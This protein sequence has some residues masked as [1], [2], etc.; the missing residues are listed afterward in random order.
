M[1]TFVPSWVE[2]TLP[3]EKKQKGPIYSVA[4][5][6]LGKRLATAGGDN[7]VKIWSTEPMF[8]SEL[9]KN[10]DT[11]RLLAVLATHQGS[12]LCV[13]WSHDM[14]SGSL[15]ASGSD[16]LKIIIWQQQEG[17]TA[18]PAF[19]ETAGGIESWRPKKL[20][21]GHTSDIMDLAWSSENK[22]LA[23]C[24]IESPIY[25]WDGKSFELIRK[26]QGH[27]SFVKGITWDPAGVYLASQS[28]DKTV[29]IW[30]T[31][32]WQEEKSVSAPYE[33]A[34]STSF[35]MRLAWSPEG[36]SILTTSGESGNQA[37][38][39][40]IERG[41]WE[42]DTKLV[43]PTLPVECA[44]FNPILFLSEPSGPTSE[45]SPCT[46]CAVGSQDSTISIWRT[47]DEKAFMVAKDLFQHSVLDMCWGPGGDSLY[48]CSYDGTVAVMLWPENDE[49]GKHA[50]L[51]TK[52][53]AMENLGSKRRTVIE[54]ATQLELEQSGKAMEISSNR[55]DTLLGRSLSTDANQP[56][57]AT[58]APAPKRSLHSETVVPLRQ[59]VS[60]T[61]DGRKRIRPTFLPSNFDSPDNA[62]SVFD[63][64]NGTDDSSGLIPMSLSKRRKAD[65]S[66]D[67]T[68]TRAVTRYVLPMVTET[69]QPVNLALPS[70]ESKL[71][72][73]IPGKAP[74]GTSTIECENRG[75]T[76]T[77]TCTVKSQKLW[78][79]HLHSHAIHVV[80]TA[81]FV[82]IGCIDGS[83]FTFSAAGRRLLP[84]IAL[85]APS[86]F[87]TAH[88]QYLMSLSSNA[89]LSVWNVARRSVV[90][91]QTSIAHLLHSAA[92][93][94]DGAGRVP[95]KDVVIKSAI[96][97]PEGI[98]ILTTSEDNQYSFHPGMKVWI[99]VGDALEPVSGGRSM[100]R[101][102]TLAQ[103]ENL[104]A[105]NTALR[106][107][108]D[109]L[110]NIKRYAIKLCDENATSKVEELCDELLGHT[111]V[112]SINMVNE[113]GPIDNWNPMIMGIPKR[114]ILQQLI[115]ILSQKR[116][117]QRIV[118]PV[119]EHLQKITESEH[120][121]RIRL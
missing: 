9:E 117:F 63:T 102:K 79:D 24:G 15:L 21:A 81:S 56:V 23:S 58:P 72:T 7:K 118:G 62:A 14:G 66:G 67:D 13:R 76:T 64:P 91:H 26:L 119:H 69:R 65:P 60:Q 11:P 106:A 87:L 25:L 89:T 104:L 90:I 109:Y 73:Q 1:L 6:P 113:P 22:Y 19:G 52:E 96:L 92:S 95:G 107:A 71:I 49:L 39:P 42:S 110:I 34:A 51:S 93:D 61:P 28:D 32:D 27:N 88:G 68:E 17:V 78:T 47:T 121:N 48:A 12:V 100:P 103:L 54:S 50:P 112:P 80:G 35:F 33:A 84:C 44:A 115:P 4:A 30:R 120:L 20:M 101:T 85:E 70:V 10:P 94:N 29:K 41:T 2:H 86:T 8:H 59:Q 114:S 82:A 45:P 57:F 55:I 3:G 37:V 38:A 105:C 99:K 75:P 77:I 16:D 36:Q 46:I 53:G 18:R 97:K 5:H 74:F 116:E 111:S 108:D 98:P 43:G 40:I 31:S 83:L